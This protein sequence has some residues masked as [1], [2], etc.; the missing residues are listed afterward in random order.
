MTQQ[1]LRSFF[2]PYIRAVYP[3]RERGGPDTLFVGEQ[4]LTAWAGQQGLTLRDAMGELLSVHIWPE[5][6]RRNY[7][8]FSVMAMRRMLE[9][10]ILLV[11][12]GGLGG[13][14]AALLARM[15]AGMLRLCDYDVFDESNLN[16]Q[17]FALHATLGK[18]KAATA[19]EGLRAMASHISCEIVDVPASAATLPALVADMDLA[20]DC[21][22]SIP[23]KMALERAALRAGVPFVHGSVLREEGFAFLTLKEARL[24]SLYPDSGRADDEKTRGQA[25]SGV[26]AAGIACLMAQ[27]C[28][29]HIRRLA[30]GRNPE[31]S[32]LYHLDYS[33]PELESFW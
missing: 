11:G 28:A 15:G 21:L 27:L 12:C 10:R 32:P 1:E 9:S 24:P 13:H 33:V 29:R 7:G 19:S 18:G 23:L 17:Y 5:R 4:G 30:E 2:A 6:F 25:M 22:D 14:V 8:L 16:R 31:P 3:S 20:V 26:A